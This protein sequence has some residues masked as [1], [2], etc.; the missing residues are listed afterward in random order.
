[1][2]SLPVL[3]I[4]APP[5]RFEA[6][7]EFLRILLQSGG[8][9]L[10]KRITPRNNL[11]GNQSLF[12]NNAENVPVLIPGFFDMR[13][14]TRDTL[15]ALPG[16]T[17]V[18]GHYSEAQRILRY[19]ARY[20]KQ[21]MVPDRLP[22]PGHPLEDCDYGSVDT[23]LWYFY[24]LDHYL[25]A[26]RDIELLDELYPHLTESIS[27]YIKGTF[28]GILVDT[29]DGL[30]QAKQPGKALTWMNAT[31][32]EVPVTPR[33]GKPVE[34]NALWYNALSLMH[35]WSQ[36]LYQKGRINHSPTYY[37]EQSALCRC[38]FNER[39]WYSTGGYLF[40]VIDG[41]D[42]NDFS[43][44]PNQLLAFSLRF[45]VLAEELRNNVLDLVT[46]QLVTPYGLRTL[47]PTEAKYQGHLKAKLVEQQRALHQ[48]LAW[49]WLLGPFIDAL[50]CVEGPTTPT[51][52]MQLINS[53]LE[54]VWQKGLR[55]LEPFRKLLNEGMLGMIGGVF[56]GDASQH[57][58]TGHMVASALSI[59]EILRVY[60]LLAHQGVKYLDRALFI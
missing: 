40:D 48:G 23:T 41:D 39:F 15:I 8:H 52:S 6:D 38:N 34:V 22:A 53:H 32:N 59:G 28:N 13:D 55:L 45:P 33:Y 11:S 14:K 42:G 56:D 57:I 2:H 10:A 9:F 30:L 36:L 18:T 16:L 7:E 43:I 51:G 50:L 26:T 4:T 24:A 25:R 49:P 46:E 21:G 12:F 3:P 35:E 5:D 54:Q 37:K 17:L 19:L 27:W 44:R 20:F 60:N 31:I 58:N 1:V 29:N 47:A